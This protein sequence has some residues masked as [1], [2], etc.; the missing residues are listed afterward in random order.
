MLPSGSYHV[1]H[2]GRY[3]EQFVKIAQPKV[4][5]GGNRGPNQQGKPANFY[6]AS[7]KD[8]KNPGGSNGTNKK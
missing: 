3:F 5:S 7:S 8:N 4:T 1:K 2:A 6:T